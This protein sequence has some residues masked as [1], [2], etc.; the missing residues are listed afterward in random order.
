MAKNNDIKVTVSEE[1]GRKTFYV[2]VKNMSGEEAKALILQAIKENGNIDIE[3]IVIQEDQNHFS[4]TLNNDGT[5]DTQ[6]LTPDSGNDD[7]LRFD[8]LNAVHAA[9]NS[10]PSEFEGQIKLGLADRIQNAIERKRDEVAQAIF[11]NQDQEI[12][13]DDPDAQ[14]PEYNPEAEEIDPEENNSEE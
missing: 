12:E 13:T 9:L 10:E 2:D 1:N 8:A 3:D 4:A 6:D 14:D 7:A 5:V 11:G